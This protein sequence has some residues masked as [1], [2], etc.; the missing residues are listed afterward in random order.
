M[1]SRLL[2]LLTDWVDAA[3]G[4]VRTEDSDDPASGG[5]TQ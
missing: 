5:F 4:R 2:L 1:E 3:D